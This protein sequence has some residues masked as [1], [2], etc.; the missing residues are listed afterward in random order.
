MSTWLDIIRLV[1]LTRELRN[2]FNATCGGDVLEN[3][4]R[5]YQ[6]A[7]PP[8]DVRYCSPLVRPRATSF[9]PFRESQVNDMLSK[10]LPY[11]RA[12]IIKVIIIMI[13][14]TVSR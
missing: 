13:I 9:Y 3:T 2:E 4:S 7:A 6:L 12:S 11:R 14:I 1:S 8:P 5:N 10:P